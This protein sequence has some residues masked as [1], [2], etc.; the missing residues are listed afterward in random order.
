MAVQ[1][2]TDL[3]NVPFITSG[4]ILQTQSGVLL[5]IGA[6]STDLLTNTLM[7]KIAA[8]GKYAPYTD[9]AAVD[10]TAIPAGFYIGDDI[11]F[12]LIA[13]G[14]V[15]NLLIATLGSVATFD[16][17]ELVLENSVTLAD[18]IGT[19]VTLTTVGDELIKKGFISEV[20]VLI[21]QPEN[22]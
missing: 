1:N 12:A 21:S 10:G 15:S 4:Q 19:G 6:R 20:T 22:A 2:S 11:A 7:A 5:T 16:P 8:T 14:D 18:V 3:K 13:A 17:D 9:V